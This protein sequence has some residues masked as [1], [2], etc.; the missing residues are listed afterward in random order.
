MWSGGA[1]ARPPCTP[2]AAWFVW[3]A[4]SEPATLVRFAS[5][6]SLASLS[7]PSLEVE[8]DMEGGGK[9]KKKRGEKKKNDS[10]PV[11]KYL[12]TNIQTNQKQQ[13]I[14][15]HAVEYIKDQLSSSFNPLLPGGPKMAHRPVLL[16]HQVP[17]REY[18]TFDCPTLH[19]A[20]TLIELCD[21]LQSMDPHINARGTAYT[22]TWS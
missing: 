10:T 20:S 21:T 16:L 9:R 2:P 3:S 7:P 19:A 1:A 17:L 18:N 8:E 15:N 22:Q 13:Q 5:L 11:R 4:P 12:I 6:T 14:F